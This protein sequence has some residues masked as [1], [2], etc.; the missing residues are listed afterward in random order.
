[1]IVDYIVAVML[2]LSII[3]YSVLG[4]ADFG[5][6]ILELFIFG[7]DAEEQ[8]NLITE[9][10]NPVWEA[11][12]V[13]LTYLIVGLFTAFPIVSQTLAYALFV[14]FSLVLIGIVFRGASFAFRSHI[15]KAVALKAFWGRFFSTASLITPFLLGTIAGAVAS[16]DLHVRNG[17]PPVAVWWPWLNPFSLV[18][19]FMALGV[20]AT[21]AATYLTVNA[22]MVEKPYLAEKF[23]VKA[24]IAAGVT[25]ALGVAGFILMPFFASVLWDGLFTRN[26]AIWAVIVT[27]VIGLA[28]GVA[29]Y[30]RHYRTARILLDLDVAAFLG[31]WGLAQVP[32]IVPPDLTIV[33]ASSPPTTMEQFLVS[34]IIGM[35]I[36]IP[37]LWLLYHVFETRS[38]MP[39]VHQREIKGV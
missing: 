3:I 12:N 29:L 34:A 7:R 39:P 23:R 20:C 21:V 24:F 30:T 19:G 10:L 27:I 17:V 15:R 33:E 35:L 22:Q 8:R 14:P 36:L 31:A 37:S 18:I 11:N 5:A 26:W 13:W 28:A 16:G 6:G 1:M 32:Y 9:A 38:P 2:W 25:A 4:G